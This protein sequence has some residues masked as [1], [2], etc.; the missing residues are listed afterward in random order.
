MKKTIKNNFIYLSFFSLYSRTWSDESLKSRILKKGHFLDK[1][2]SENKK[3]IILVRQIGLLLNEYFRRGLFVDES[4]RWVWDIY[5]IFHVGNVLKHENSKNNLSNK[6]S[7]I[8]KLIKERRS[9]R[10]WQ[11]KKVNVNLVIKAID[12]AK[13]APVSCNRQAWKFI[14]LTKQEDINF[15]KNLTNQTFFTNSKILVLALANSE[16]YTKGE[17]CYMYLDMG[18]IIQNMLLLL[19]SYNIGSCW[20]GFKNTETDGKVLKEFYNKFKIDK[21]YILVSF[22]P[23]GLISNIPI[24]PSRKETTEIVEVR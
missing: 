5:K 7:E 19:Y 4:I 24:A 6:A 15:I 20:M 3:N 11:N 14:L 16:S 12:K 9:I 21:K 22:I 18:A 8:E 10:K 2:N 13:W 1:L 17:G 23:L